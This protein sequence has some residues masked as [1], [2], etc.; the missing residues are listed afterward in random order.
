M[1]GRLALLSPTDSVKGILNVA[2]ILTR[3][4]SRRLL[5]SGLIDNYN[6]L[7]DL[8]ADTRVQEAGRFDIHRPPQHFR[9]RQ[10]F[11]GNPPDICPADRPWFR[12]GRGNIFK[13]G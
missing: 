1:G 10:W 13:A 8:L 6:S 2:D 3:M 9:D 7:D 5:F 11:I 12:P 4:S